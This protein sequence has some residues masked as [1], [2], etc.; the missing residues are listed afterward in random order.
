MVPADVKA[1]MRRRASACS[2]GTAPAWRGTSRST[3]PRGLLRARASRDPPG[4]PVRPLR[5]RAAA[6]DR[7]HAGRPRGSRRLRRGPAVHSPSKGWSRGSHRARG[8][9][10]VRHRRVFKVGGAQ[11]IAAMALG[12]ASI[13]A[14]HKFF[15][16]GN[17]FVTSA[18]QQV[19][20]MPGGPA[21]D[22]P[23]GPSEVLV[24]ADA[25]ASPAFVAATS[26]PR[27][28]MARTRR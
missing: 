9:A 12:T 10:A 13:P 1:A 17:S 14:C 2:P 18:K 7:P 27:P 6:L 4:R 23:A 15:G 3:P 28:S 24:I 11:A 5:L 19:A 16:P 22:M 21:I 25:G 20:M 8:R 26:S